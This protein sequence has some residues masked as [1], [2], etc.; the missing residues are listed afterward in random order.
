MRGWGG[1]YGFHN[2]V[3]QTCTLK[4]YEKEKVSVGGEIL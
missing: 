2:R 3:R 1:G 4:V